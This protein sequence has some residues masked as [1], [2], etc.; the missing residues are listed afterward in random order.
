MSVFAD[1]ITTA[2]VLALVDVHAG[3]PAL[4]ECR[5]IKL[6]SVPACAGVSPGAG[7]TGF[8]TFVAIICAPTSVSFSEGNCSTGWVLFNPVVEAYFA[9]A[10]LEAHL[11]GI[12]AVALFDIFAQL[13]PIA[14][15]TAVALALERPFGVRARCFTV[16]NIRGVA[17]ILV[18]AGLPAILCNPAVA[19]GACVRALRVSAYSAG[20]VRAFVRCRQK[21]LVDVAAVGAVTSGVVF[22][23]REAI[24][25]VRPFRC[26]LATGGF[27]GAVM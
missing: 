21:T 12:L 7:G 16:A 25:S 8:R 27:G 2:R 3:L 26:V 20:T 11:L 19:A 18:I 4:C 9:G 5:V 1:R 15:P 17:L 24:A 6:E 14:F 13:E 22:V 10:A 23:S